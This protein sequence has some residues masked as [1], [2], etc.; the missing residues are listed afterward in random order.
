M[1]LY[2]PKRSIFNVSAEDIE[3]A[4][5]LRNIIENNPKLMSIFKDIMSDENDKQTNKTFRRRNDKKNKRKEKY[6]LQKIRKI[7]KSFSNCIKRIF[8]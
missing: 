4:T 5:K 6:F 7:L 1:I 2:E 3:N 8:T